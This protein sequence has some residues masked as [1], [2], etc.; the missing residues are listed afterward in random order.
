MKQITIPGK[1]PIKDISESSIPRCRY[2]NNVRENFESLLEEKLNF[3]IR[4]ASEY[5]TI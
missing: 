4:D 3:F 1:N 2:S 5:G